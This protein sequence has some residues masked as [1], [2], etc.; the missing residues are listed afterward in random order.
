MIKIDSKGE[1]LVA[2]PAQAAT[3]DTTCPLLIMARLKAKTGVHVVFNLSVSL[4]AMNMVLLVFPV[5][6]TV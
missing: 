2:F 3:A 6:P 1:I 5:T 4:T